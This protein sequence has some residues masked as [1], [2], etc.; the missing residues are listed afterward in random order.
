M[1]SKVELA[2]ESVR[3]FKDVF[4]F[5]HLKQ[6]SLNTKRSKI[7]FRNLLVEEVYFFAFNITAL[8]LENFLID[9]IGQGGRVEGTTVPPNNEILDILVIFHNLSKRSVI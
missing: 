8:R 9:G 3:F 2:F 5:F 7:L 6:N 1:E 4:L